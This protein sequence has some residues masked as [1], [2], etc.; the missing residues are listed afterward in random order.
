MSGDTFKRDMIPTITIEYIEEVIY[1]N[2]IDIQDSYS[3]IANFGNSITTEQI[4][5]NN[6]INNGNLQTSSINVNN[7]KFTANDTTGNIISGS[8]DAQ[9]ISSNVK[10]SSSDIST[11]QFPS[12]NNSFQ[13]IYDNFQIKNLAIDNLQTDLLDLTDVVSDNTA[14]IAFL[15][16]EVNTQNVISNTI[17]NTD[18][19]TNSLSINNNLNVDSNGNTNIVGSLNVDGN[20]NMGKLN[21]TGNLSGTNS[22][23]NNF[24]SNGITTNN[25][26]IGNN[27]SVNNIITNNVNIITPVMTNIFAN[28]DLTSGGANLNNVIT[29]DFTVSG[30]VNLNNNLSVSK[31]T[32]LNGLLLLPLYSSN[33]LINLPNPQNGMIIFNTTTRSVFSYQ[34]DNWTSV[35]GDVE[36]ISAYIPNQLEVD[37]IVNNNDLEVL[38]NTIMETVYINQ[39][40]ITNTTQINGIFMIDANDTIIDPLTG[41][42]NIGGSINIE[43][44]TTI[45]N[46]NAQNTTFN[47]LLVL[48]NQT[49]N[50]NVNVGNNLTILGQTQ[51]ANV[52]II[53]TLTITGSN[54]LIPPLTITTGGVGFEILKITD[55]DNNKKF[56]VN[57]N[58]ILLT[59]GNVNLL[60][61]LLVSGTTNLQNL[62]TTNMILS[63]TL[64]ISGNSNMV[65]L[66]VNNITISGLT[67]FN[68]LII[69]QDLIT[70]NFNV[71]LLNA[72]YLNILNK[73]VLP[74]YTT[75][76][77][78]NLTASNGMIIYNTN[79]NSIYV[80]QNNSWISISGQLT[81]TNITFNNGITTNNLTSNILTTTTLNLTNGIINSI[82]VNGTTNMNNITVSGN[83]TFTGI[84]LNNG[85]IINNSTTSTTIN[86]I[87]AVN[88][89]LSGNLSVGSLN[90]SNNTAFNTFNSINSQNINVGSQNIVNK[91]SGGNIRFNTLTYNSS[92][93]TSGTVFDA[94]LATT[95]MIV[96][97]G[98]DLQ[99][100]TVNEGLF[101]YNTSSKLFEGVYELPAIWKSFSGFA[102]IITNPQLSDQIY[103]DGTNW[104]NGVYVQAP[105]ISSFTNNSAITTSSFTTYNYNLVFTRTNWQLYDSTGTI[106]IFDTG[107]LNS[108]TLNYDFTNYVNGLVN[109]NYK[110][111]LRFGGQSTYNSLSP[112]SSFFNGVSTYYINIPSI[113]S[114]TN[115]RAI[116]SSFSSYI[117]GL[118]LGNSK[119]RLYNSSGTTII[120]ESGSG[121]DG[122]ITQFDFT[123]YV[124]GLTPTTYNISV[125]YRGN[126]ATYGY[127]NWSPLYSAISSLF[128]T[129]PTITPPTTKSVTASALSSYIS[130]LTLYSSDWQIYNLAGTTLILSVTQI[131]SSTTYDFSSYIGVGNTLIPA[132]TYKVTVRYTGRSG[133]N[134][135]N[136]N[137][138]TQVNWKI[139][140]IEFSPTSGS[141]INTSYYRRTYEQYIYITASGTVSVSIS[142]LPYGLSYSTSYNS[143]TTT[144]LINN[145]S[146]NPVSSYASRWITITATDT[147]NF[148]SS[149][150]YLMYE[151][152]YISDLSI[153]IPNN[154]STALEVSSGGFR[155]VSFSSDIRCY[156]YKVVD[157]SGSVFIMSSDS[158]YPFSNYSISS[159]GFGYSL[160]SSTGELTKPTYDNGNFT[161][162]TLNAQYNG[163]SISPRQ[164]YMLGYGTGFGVPEI[165][166]GI[167]D[168]NSGTIIYNPISLATN[169]IVL[170]Y[171]NNTVSSNFF[172][173]RSTTSFG[174]ISRRYY[175]R[176]DNGDIY[177]SDLLSVLYLTD[178]STSGIIALSNTE[179]AFRLI[180]N[181][182][183]SFMRSRN[184]SLTTYLEFFDSLYRLTTISISIYIIF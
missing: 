62:N 174:V 21:L 25:I 1:Q 24:S 121:G 36:A 147:S 59:D 101:R 10:I 181:Q 96:P 126:N 119:W 183:S 118:T 145:Y 155:G 4:T 70:N 5:T 144:V 98:N 105:S 9:N 115:N 139:P 162:M 97:K 106:L 170:S 67:I 19:N 161:G 151:Y 177:S 32:Q 156:V 130:G 6:V 42:T 81:G 123:N 149:A 172:F 53:K 91:I 11:S 29:Q 154:Y 122:A 153:Y 47:E 71:S 104:V 143:N 51:K 50:N 152:F 48:T 110:L 99:K 52:H 37:Q 107:V 40:V 87:N 7:G 61:G 58:C 43:N 109:T 65:T 180:N 164:I 175:I 54:N 165:E 14:D 3:K 23:F 117:S 111:R 133:V 142:N 66:N 85:I 75:I 92:T 108:T 68:N 103:F 167:Q 102:P 55:T 83:G 182:A 179:K 90:V 12:I 140:S 132:E 160:N 112:W 93:P 22:N 124:N 76:D 129:T 114:F 135:Y 134:S 125:S 20:T 41:N 64:N 127:S 131:S 57:N 80:Y 38:G 84:V 34:N 184:G 150:S 171:S 27:S 176:L 178:G 136:S 56:I 60:N 2:N 95:S 13:Q 69:L 73:I 86:T 46:L 78:E 100:P 94:S 35:T 148:S 33:D 74:S 169:S 8:I 30:N 45:N 39:N 49:V 128:I 63:G 159:G 116:A 18:V 44:N 77:M 15:G 17:N 157:G 146:L 88:S 163:I 31:S 89:T 173:V 137:W 158:N 79:T 26:T 138:A 72:T 120:Y 141:T 168:P 82:S 28:S 166:I 16:T 113:T